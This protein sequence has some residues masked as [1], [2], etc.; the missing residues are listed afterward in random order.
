MILQDYRESGKPKQTPSIK[1]FFSDSKSS[2][3]IVTHKQFSIFSF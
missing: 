1:D 2:F 3:K